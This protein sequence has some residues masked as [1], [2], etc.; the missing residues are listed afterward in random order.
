MG[1]NKKNEIRTGPGYARGERGANIYSWQLEYT[2]QLSGKLSLTGKLNYASVK[3]ELAQ[4]SG[5]GDIFLSVTNTSGLRKKWQKSVVAGFK[6]PLNNA[7]KNKN[8][9]HLP[10]LYQTSLGT[11]DLLLGIN[12]S[13]KSFGASLAYQQPLNSVNKNKFLQSAYPLVPAV[14][15]YPSSNAFSRKADIVAQ[16]SYSFKTGK[17]FSMRPGLLGI[18]HAGNDSYLDENNIK[19]TI[20]NSKG[21]TLNTTVFFQYETGERSGLVLSAGTPVISRSQRP[22]G[23]T[24]KVVTAFEYY[25]RF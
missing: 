6:V 25:F 12:I 9:I 13:R 10:M 21:L 4:T 24:R 22:D 17:H 2:R 23:L 11:T 5:L 19:K 3:G 14:A 1:P 20:I 15:Y 7:G 18:Y 16:L 8:G